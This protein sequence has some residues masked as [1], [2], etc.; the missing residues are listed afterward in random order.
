MSERETTIPDRPTGLAGAALEGVLLALLGMFLAWT[1]LAQPEVWIDDAFIHFRNARNFAEGLGLVFNPGERVIGS[2]SPVYVF[3]LGLASRLTGFEVPGVATVVNLMADAGTAGLCLWLLSSAGMPRVFRYAVVFTVFSEP[4]GMLYSVAGMEMSLFLVAATAIVAS[5]DRGWWWPAGLML[6]AL[7]WIRPEG[8]TVGL[9][10]IV[11]LALARRPGEAMKTAG[12]A[13]AVALAVG[14]AL[15]LYYGSVVPQSV[16]AKASAAPWFPTEGRQDAWLF[17]QY[18]AR[19]GPLPAVVTGAIGSEE[20]GA[21]IARIIFGALQAGLMVLGGVWWFRRRPVAGA[22]LLG[23]AALYFLFYAVTNPRLFQWYYVPLGFLGTLLAGAGWWAMVERVIRFAVDHGEM[24]AASAPVWGAVAGV[25]LAGVVMLG[26]SNVAAGSARFVGVGRWERYAF[27]MLPQSPIDRLTLYEH[28]AKIMEEWR[29]T[30]PEGV[31]ATPEIGV[32]GWWYRGTVL[33]PY[34]LVSPEALDV[35]EPEAQA[36]L[37]EE[38]RAYHPMNVYLIEEPEFIMTAEMFLPYVPEEMAE[39]Y[40]EVKRGEIPVIRF[41]VR[42][43]VAE[44]V[45]R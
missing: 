17:F 20:G 12:V 5:S 42:R 38:L 40:V 15:F 4:L 9:A 28:A 18:L 44:K 11:G 16:I 32:F 37:T 22:A 26:H 8:V 34:G 29:E 45:E 3:V 6:G 25:A 36:K 39:K 35:L 21:G 13:A 2:T 30:A 10:V 33:D 43:D 1:R 23:F 14:S 41:F 19:L 27:R 24:R 31:A 7:G